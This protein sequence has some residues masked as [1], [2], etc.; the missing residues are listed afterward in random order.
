MSWQTAV[1]AAK[2]DRVVISFGAWANLEMN[3][4][5]K[6]M[7]CIH[8]SSLPIANGQ[9]SEKNEISYRF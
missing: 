1:V 6:Q 7:I 8:S 2:L 5:S 4:I 3:L 9:I